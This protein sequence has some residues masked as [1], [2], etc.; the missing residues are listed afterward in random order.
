MYQ[1]TRTMF[2]NLVKERKG[3]ELKMNPYKQNNKTK[4]HIQKKVINTCVFKQKVVP[5]QS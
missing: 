4:I 5:L 1:M 2:N 3:N